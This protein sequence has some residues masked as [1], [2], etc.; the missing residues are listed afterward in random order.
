MLP[1]QI[2]SEA[3]RLAIRGPSG[4]GKSSLLRA[5]AGHAKIGTLRI[6]GQTWEGPGVWVPPWS[7]GVGWAPQDPLL[8]PHI[9]VDGLLCWATP[10]ADPGPVAALLEL[11]P[12]LARRPRHL[13]GGERQRVAIGRALMAARTCLL[14]DE[15][16]SALD[17]ALR[18]RV[19]RAVDEWTRERDLSVI[20]VSH[21]ARDLDR[22]ADDVVEIGRSTLHSRHGMGVSSG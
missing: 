13:S 9:R 14:L 22:I 20:V 5:I 12:L 1:V 7:R 16:F 18:L 3:R 17:E 21:D 6:G 8:P 10:G 19:T 4:V 11:V 2:H 15:P